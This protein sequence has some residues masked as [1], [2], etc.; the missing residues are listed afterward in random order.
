MNMQ[1]PNN[2]LLARV[3]REVQADSPQ[4]KKAG[5]AKCQTGFKLVQLCRMNRVKISMLNQITA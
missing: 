3:K 2:R 1:T 4:N 5:P